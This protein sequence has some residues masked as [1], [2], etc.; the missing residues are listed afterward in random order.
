MLQSVAQIEL[1]G[2]LPGLNPAALELAADWNRGDV[3]GHVGIDMKMFLAAAQADPA[4]RGSFTTILARLA[5]L[6]GP[7]D[8]QG[9]WAIA[10]LGHLTSLVVT[11]YAQL[12][13]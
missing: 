11:E 12:A 5:D 3:T 7:A 1:E 9:T 8:E 4:I 10:A 2:A 6:A 13:P